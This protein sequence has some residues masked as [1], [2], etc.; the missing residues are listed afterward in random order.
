MGRHIQ[1]NKII[2]NLKQHNNFKNILQKQRK[3]TFSPTTWN[4]NK[5]FNGHKHM[6][7]HRYWKMVVQNSHF[8]LQW[9]K[10]IMQGHVKDNEDNL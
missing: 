6:S 4:K 9:T 5:D 3:L 10:V 2:C 7:K 8:P 1:N